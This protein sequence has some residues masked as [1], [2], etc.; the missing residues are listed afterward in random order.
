M[1]FTGVAVVQQV[2]DKKVR[3]TGVSLDA[4]ATGTIALSGGTADVLL[5]AAFQ[6]S[7]YGYEG[8]TVE[9]QASIEVRVWP[10]D[11]SPPSGLAVP[12]QIEK[13]GTTATDFLITLFNSSGVELG[14]DS[15]LL[16]IYV[17]FH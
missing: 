3:I 12:V 9:L 5:P 10:A 11:P 15:G 6:P 2:A 8:D 4:N 14:E 13:T 7:P 17:E 1:A 16:E